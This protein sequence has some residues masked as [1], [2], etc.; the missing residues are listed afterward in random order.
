VM[1]I[2]PLADPIQLGVAKATSF[3]PSK[4][5]SLLFVSLVS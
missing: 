2:V 5:L 4:K 3:W 1:N